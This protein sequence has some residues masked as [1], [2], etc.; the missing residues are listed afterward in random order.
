METGR[1]TVE[2]EDTASDDKSPVDFS[3]KAWIALS[4]CPTTYRKAK[5]G[6]VEL[7]LDPRHPL[8]STAMNNNVMVNSAFI[9]CFPHS[10][11]NKERPLPRAIMCL[12][13]LASCESV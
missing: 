7:L 13:R 12:N 2:K 5:V 8:R 1:G 10:S 3:L 9:R 6:A 11:G 4:P